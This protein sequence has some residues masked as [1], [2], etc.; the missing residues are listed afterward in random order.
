[1]RIAV[2]SDTHGNLTAFETVLEDID[3][4]G[5]DRIYHLGDV[6]GKG[7][8]GNA[9]CDLARE[10][11]EATTRGNWDLSLLNADPD[12]DSAYS[13]W[14][15]EISD[16]NLEWLAMLPFSVDFELANTP[17]RC[18][19]A[20]SDDVFHRIRRDVDGDEWDYVFQNTETTGDAAPEPKV[21]IYG[22]IHYA[23][24]RSDGER[25]LLNCGAVGN[26]L[27]E[28]TASYIV[29]DDATG[30]LQWE[31]IRVPYDI[32]AEL[33]AGRELKMPQY[34]SWEHELR[35]ADYSR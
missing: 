15:N 7:P 4:R 22:D 24:S 9:C 31:L 33:A 13:W 19:H 8:R 5:V 28:P 21:V 35:T 25:T 32:E 16:E 23:W 3:H 34:R 1:M 18:F 10:R 11:C 20:S 2:L 30:T 12:G 27:D 17:I 6:A 26:P 14:R 29:L